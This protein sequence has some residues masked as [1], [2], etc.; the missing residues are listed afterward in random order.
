MELITIGV[1]CGGGGCFLVNGYLNFN[2]KKD[3]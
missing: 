1:F 3:L 2:K